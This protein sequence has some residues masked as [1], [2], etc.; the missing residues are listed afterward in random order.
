M[1]ERA[2][3]IRRRLIEADAR[4]AASPENGSGEVRHFAW[5]NWP[6]WPNWMNWRNWRNW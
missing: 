5:G 3:E 4:D 2:D 6:N 1:I